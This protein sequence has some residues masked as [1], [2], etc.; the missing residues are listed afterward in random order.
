MELR[1]KNSKNESC[2]KWGHECR[3]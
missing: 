2:S 3:G 1:L